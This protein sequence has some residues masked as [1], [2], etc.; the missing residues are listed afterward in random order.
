V[1]RRLKLIE[2][3][4]CFLV[5]SCSCSAWS[6]KTG[7]E[8]HLVPNGPVMALTIAAAPA[9][10]VPPRAAPPPPVAQPAAA[11]PA[12]ASS[13]EQQAA[14]NRLLNNY[15]ADQSQNI[16]GNVLTAL[17]RQITAAA[18]SLGQPVTL[19]QAPAAATPVAAPV[20]GRLNL[21]V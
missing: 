13:R 6:T 20:A 17:G 5:L 11:A 19:P 2:S 18:Q 3:F 21:T 10:H 8:P 14:L 12:A 4:Y 15:Q 7:G 1:D 9:H 16:G